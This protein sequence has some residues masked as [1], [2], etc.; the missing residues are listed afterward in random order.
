MQGLMMFRAVLIVPMLQ[1]IWTVLAIIGGG[2]Y[3]QARP[4][5]VFVDV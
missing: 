4:H 2:I 3:F 1:V 5:H